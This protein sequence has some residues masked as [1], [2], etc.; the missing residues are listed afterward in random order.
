[1]GAV[2]K[3]VETPYETDRYGRTQA[4]ARALRERDWRG[5][6]VP[7]PIERSEGRRP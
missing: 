6:D 3:A 2:E 7:H 4:T 5:R 1:M